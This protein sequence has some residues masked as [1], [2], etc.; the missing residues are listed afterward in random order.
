MPSEAQWEYAARAGTTTAFNNGTEDWEETALEG[1]GWFSFNS[2]SMTHE[3]GKK[4]ANT[5]GLHDMHGN[6]FEWCWDWFGTYPSNAQ[7]DPLGA[8]SGSIRVG[9]GGGW[10]N[11]AQVARSAYRG[12]VNPFDRYN[13][14]GFRLLRP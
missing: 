7:T 1:I 11:S 2:G 4:A 6:V 12:L 9:R 10:G 8:S 13:G 5:W 14:L 3:V